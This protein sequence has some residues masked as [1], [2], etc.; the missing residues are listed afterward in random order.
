MVGLTVQNF[1]SAAAGMAVM[2]AL[3]RGLSRA[4]Q[5]TDR[6]L[7]GRPHPHRPAH[8]APDR[9]RVRDR[10]DRH[11][12]DPEPPRLH[13]RAHRRRRHAEDPGRAGGQPGVD[14]DARHQ[15]WR[16]LQREL[17]PPVREPDE[18]QRLPR[19][20]LDPD[21][22]VRPRVHLRAHGEGQA[23]GLRGGRGDGRPLVRRRGHAPVPGDR[24]QPEARR[25]GRDPDRH[26]HVTRRQPRGQGAA[27]RRRVLRARGARPP[28]GRRTARSTRCTTATRRPAGW[29][30]W[31]T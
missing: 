5:R 6:Q 8:P 23:P 15:R 24:R 22:P 1:V 25:P 14:Q 27:V 20:L 4:G 2:V 9:V 31:S 10:A 21:H 12:R 18:V 19:A 29:S 7:L 13:R 17:G 16:V 11:R 3:I 30:P 28:P 26:R